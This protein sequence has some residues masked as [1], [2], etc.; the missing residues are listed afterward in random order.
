MRVGLLT[1][2][3]SRHAGGLFDSV[4]GL[5]GH[6]AATRDAEVLAFG[7]DDGDTTSHDLA[8]W[9]G[10]PVRAF[11]VK[12]SQVFGYAPGLMSALETANLDLLHVHG[13][14]KYPS[15]ASLLWARRS[16]RPVMISP[17][18]MLDPWAVRQS[19]WKKRIARR[20]YEDRHLRN[21]ACLHAV[22]S[23]EASAIRVCGLHNPICIIPN[24]VDL[25]P[26]ELGVTPPWQ[27]ELPDGAKVVL[28]LGR[29][30]PKKNLTGL[31]LGWARGTA[32][33]DLG[34]WWLVIA[35]W[36]QG[37]HENALRDLVR[38]RNIPRVLFAGPQ[39]ESEKRATFRR[40]E[41]FVLASYSEGLPRAV[42][43]AW[44]NRL[45]V[46]MTPACNL[47]EAFTAGAAVAIS[48]EPDSI[49][50]GLT[51]LLRCP[52]RQRRAMGSVGR[53]L[54]EREFVWP[55]ITRQTLAVYRWMLGEGTRP[56]C[57]VTI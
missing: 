24:A 14:W 55:V 48:T 35:G 27:R 9:D 30:H 42:L 26:D 2:S 49:A 17:H 3:V 44:A 45:P 50:G 34:D 25:P 39:F 28:Y 57:V 4:R 41:V 21:A 7:L 16:R 43:E 54:V 11:P 56:K 33:A 53:A 51:T 29:L 36:D 13:L 23:A 52:E 8:A 1:A 19:Y 46:M 10:V 18:G 37:G 6:L 31:L 12:G 32:A 40:A 5:S 22:S 15:V 47:P 38:S 20:L